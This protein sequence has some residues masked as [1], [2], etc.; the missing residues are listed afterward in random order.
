[1]IH[2]R[3][4]LL[5]TPLCLAG[6]VLSMIVA[7]GCA[8]D[9]EGEAPS[10]LSCAKTASAG[11]TAA[12]K[13]A[14]ASAGAGACVILTGQS[15]DGPL[16]IPQGV[17]LAGRTGTRTVITGSNPQL[18]A[19]YVGENS[20][21]ANVEV[22]DAVGVAIGVRAS[23][24][25]LSNVAVSGAKK[26][27]L[28]VS[29]VGDGCGAGLV[30]IIDSTFENSSIGVIVG[31][32]HVLLKGGK[33]S[34]HAS[35]SLSAAMGVVAQ[36][37]ARLELDGFTVEKNQGPGIVIDGAATTAFIKGST[38]SE[39]GERGIWIQKVSGSLDAP[40]VKI[41]ASTLVKNKIVGVGSVEAR[42][43]IVIGG[44][45]A[46][47]IAAPV[48]TT[49]DKPAEVGDGFGF[50]DKSSDLKID[51]TVIES[52]M[53][54]AGIIDG[55]DR[56]IIVIGGNVSAGPSG[57]KVVVQNTT[58]GEVTVPDADKSAPASPL[59]IAAPRLT[60]PPTGL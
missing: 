51:G 10:G 60:L 40:A 37:G 22:K 36:S 33:S 3:L 52:N 14:L 4:R 49:L 38:I 42:G 27:A 48:V 13:S 8:S 47:T 25:K 15:Y 1:M 32:A 23:K 46:E 57:L 24:A 2:L 41:E 30:E 59:G 18:P 55:S 11:D 29:C 9:P 53:R 17:T 39:N 21:L 35:T 16:E 7:P 58:G 5:G 31:G 45:I 28:A 19:I 56:G 54:A 20:G 12:A 34:G 43:I 44:R 50:F 6:S 26:A